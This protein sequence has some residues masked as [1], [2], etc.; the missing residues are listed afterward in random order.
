[1]HTELTYSLDLT[2]Y[3]SHAC[4]FILP[5]STIFNLFYLPVV[6]TSTVH[7]HLQLVAYDIATFIQIN[8]ALHSK[9]TVAHL[10]ERTVE[11]FLPP[12]IGKIVLTYATLLDPSQEV[13][14]VQFISIGF[15]DPQGQ[16]IA[17]YHLLVGRAEPIQPPSSVTVPS[18]IPS[19]IQVLYWQ[20]PH[21]YVPIA[22]AA[23]DTMANRGW[24]SFH[25]FDSGPPPPGCK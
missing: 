2:V 3:I 7:L 25:G 10:A 24:N 22:H 21:T 4:S 18:S 11:C 14:K 5:V 8:T 6:F 19:V 17:Y 12:T 15:F 13:K 20:P 16:Q 1:M 23:P 9:G